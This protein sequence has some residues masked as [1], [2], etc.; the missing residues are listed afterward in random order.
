MKKYILVEVDSN[1]ELFSETFGQ[2]RFA[3]KCLLDAENNGHKSILFIVE[4][5]DSGSIYIDT[6]DYSN[7]QIKKCLD[8][9]FEWKILGTASLAGIDVRDVS[10]INR[11]ESEMVKE[12][13]ILEIDFS[14]VRKDLDH[15][16]WLR[17]IEKQMKYKIEEYCK[18]KVTL[19]ESRDG[20]P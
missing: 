11:D 16:A 14:V 2:E 5:D 15:V 7:V 13:I 8:L 6:E 9:I 1:G 19:K 20:T 17:E 18:C 4:S 12:S 10:F 3:R